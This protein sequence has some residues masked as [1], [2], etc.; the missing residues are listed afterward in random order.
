MTKH[1]IKEEQIA[2]AKWLDWGMK[3]GLLL[4]I[5]TFIIYITGI[6]PPQIPISELPKY[7]KLKAYKYLS[8]AGLQPGWAWLSMTTKG[9]FLN[10]LPIALLGAVTIFCYI[11]ILPIFLKQKDI[12]YFIF[13]FVECLILLLAASGFLHVGH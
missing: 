2:Y 13:A 4:L 3:I 8:S 1:E 10:F 7:W 6:L 9:D 5:I 11:R 12:A